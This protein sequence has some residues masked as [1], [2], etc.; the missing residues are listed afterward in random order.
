ML[1]NVQQM[2]LK[3]L[4]KE[5]FKKQQKQLLIWLQKMIANR[6]KILK[7]N[8][9]QNHSERVTNEPGKEISEERYL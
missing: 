9:Q 8:S 1:K 3:L 4:Q 5:Q 6:I 2:H 7:R